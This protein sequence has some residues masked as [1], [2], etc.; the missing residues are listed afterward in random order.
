MEGLRHGA[1][2]ELKEMGRLKREFRGFLTCEEIPLAW[3]A[4][5]SGVRK[6]FGRTHTTKYLIYL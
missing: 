4:L 6:K 2:L 3:S 1:S 5:F